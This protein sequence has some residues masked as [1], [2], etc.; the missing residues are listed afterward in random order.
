M[1]ATM[2]VRKEYDEAAKAVLI[3]LKEEAEQKG[4]M[5]SGR[6]V[7]LAEALKAL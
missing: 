5:D 3:A 7:A 2:N 1:I 6:I 4:Q